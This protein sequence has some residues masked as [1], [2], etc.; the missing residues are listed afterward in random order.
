MILKI[1]QNSDLS[2]KENFLLYHWLLIVNLEYSVIDIK[3][4]KIFFS[5][6]I[7]NYNKI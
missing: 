4:I 3:I 2:I 6:F 5:F 1:D 7:F